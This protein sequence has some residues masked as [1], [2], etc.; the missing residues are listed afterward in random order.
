[1]KTIKQ[2]ITATISLCIVT[3]A[4]LAQQ[5]NADHENE[6]QKIY[7]DGYVSQGEGIAGWNADGSGPE[8][9]AY[10]HVIPAP[11]YGHQ[12]YYLSSQDLISGNPRN[13]GFHFLQ[14]MAGFENFEKTLNDYGFSADQ[15]KVKLG[16]TTLGEDLEGLDWFFINKTSYANYYNIKVTFELDGTPILEGMFDYANMNIKTPGGNWQFVSGFTPVANIAIDDTPANTIAEAFL[17]DLNGQ[18]IQIAFTA[19]F[20]RNFFSNGRAGTYYNVL[21]GKLITGRPQL[22]F[23]GLKENNEGFAAWDAN[24]YGPEPYGEGQGDHPYYRASVDYDGIN[25]SKNAALGHFVDHSSGFFNTLLQLNYRGYKISDLK[26]KMGLSSRGHDVYGEGWGVTKDQSQSW[27][28]YYNNSYVIELNGIPILHLM[29]DKDKLVLDAHGIY[30]ANATFGKVYNFENESYNHNCVAESFLKDLGTHLLISKFD[31]IVS[32]ENSSFME[33]GRKGN[34]WEIHDGSFIGVREKG[35]FIPEGEVSGIWSTDQSPYYVDGNLKVSESQTW[36]I[37]AGT[38]VIMRGPYSINVEGRVLAKGDCGKEIVFTRSNPA[39]WWDGFEYYNTQSRQPSIFNECIFEYSA[40]QG[41]GSL[42]SGGVFD[43][44]NYNQLH[45]LSSE[46]RNNKA[47]KGIR[48]GGGAIA[49]H[50]SSPMIQ[51]C[52]FHKNFSKYG[53]A[54]MAYEN[55]NPIISNCVLYENKASYGGAIALHTN[56]GGV[57]INNTIAD[58]RATCGGGL[59]IA[60]QSNGEF[61]NNIIWGNKALSYGDQVCFQGYTNFPAFYYNNCQ[62][63][64]NHFAGH[65][66]GEYLFNIDENPQFD[67][68]PEALPYSISQTS[69]C[70]NRGTPEGSPWFYLP[71]LP[72]CCPCGNARVCGGCVDI[73]AYEVK[74]CEGKMMEETKNEKTELITSVEAYPNPFIENINVNL[75]LTES[76]IVTLEIYNSIG[77][78]MLPSESFYLSEGPQHVNTD[79]SSLPEGIYVLMIKFEDTVLT[80]KLLKAR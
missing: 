55:S 35:T 40:A 71:Y 58:N 31:K 42:K 3:S 23:V 16:L 34:F 20:E 39:I 30:S 45:I 68:N 11:G 43:V 67:T 65:F 52:F 79:L 75:D 29:Q 41:E 38:K 53:G 63:G 57:L 15:L 56:S 73:G 77:Q 59:Y 54:I 13:A 33:N 27:C 7:F 62:G 8:P 78:M 22:F 76:G 72:T 2:I 19:I 17:S 48:S 21:K 80:Q 28:Y 10:G 49:L 47:D 60:L 37:E 64:Y 46:F 6:S 4:L 14:N 66:G 36:I 1:M 44:R 70:V 61:I 24:G 18:E 69:P 5:N 51:R 26:I 74:A 32:L 50:N 25:P 9:A 12:F